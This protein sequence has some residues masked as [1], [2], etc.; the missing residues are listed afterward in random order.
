MGSLLRF[1]LSNRKL[2]LTS[3][4]DWYCVWA[5]YGVLVCGMFLNCRFGKLRD[6]VPGESADE[7]RASNGTCLPGVSKIRATWEFPKIRGPNIDPQSIGLLLQGHPKKDPQFTETAT[8]MESRGWRWLVSG[9]DKKI[10]Q[11]KSYQASSEP[12]IHLAASINRGPQNKPQYTMILTIR[13]SKSNPNVLWSLSP[14]R[15]P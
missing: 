1:C 7:K 9:F 6:R 5:C 2:T 10:L 14:Q 13:D 3:H 11:A 4:G 8:W 12:G 15:G